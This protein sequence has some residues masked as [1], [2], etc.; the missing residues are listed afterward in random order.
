MHSLH[1]D[2]LYREIVQAHVEEALYVQMIAAPAP[3]NRMSCLKVETC[4]PPLRLES[5][6]ELSSYSQ[7]T[8]GMQAHAQSTG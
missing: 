6:A 5:A 8:W 3:Q 4:M 1:D 2:M 7:Q